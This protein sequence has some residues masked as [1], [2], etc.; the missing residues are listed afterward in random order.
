MQVGLRPE[1]AA[2]APAVVVASSPFMELSALPAQPAA[3][4][5]SPF[6][7]AVT[8]A[9]NHSPSPFVA[10]GAEAA[11]KDATS[12][13][14]V[15]PFDSGDGRSPF[16]FPAVAV[17]SLNPVAAANTTNPGAAANTTNPVAAANTT[18]RAIRRC[19]LHSREEGRVPANMHR[20]IC[21][22]RLRPSASSGCGRYG[23]CPMALVGVSKHE[24]MPELLE[25]V[26]EAVRTVGHED[27]GTYHVC[28]TGPQSV[29]AAKLFG[30]ALEFLEAGGRVRVELGNDG[31]G[32]PC[33][34]IVRD[35]AVAAAR[36][37]VRNAL[38]RI[39]RRS[40]TT[41]SQA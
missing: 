34:C 11:T 35:T 22:L 39:V 38:Y 29:A 24:R 7:G 9:A 12:A 14:A 3:D 8:A 33:D 6:A 5:K 28:L 1:Q 30:D 36:M 2:A 15:S 13:K 21:A 27:T 16:S 31:R 32:R 37:R 19:I 41:A 25:E 4:A 40:S 20:R 18:D 10:H 23:L 26:V 17:P